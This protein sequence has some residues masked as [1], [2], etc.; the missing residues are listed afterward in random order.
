MN[1]RIMTSQ[2]RSLLVL[3]FLLTQVCS[4]ASLANAAGNPI[5]FSTLR[6]AQKHCPT[7]TVVWLNLPTGIYHYKGEKSYGS[8]KNGA[9]VCEKE[10][11][12]AGDRATQNGQ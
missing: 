5:L 9:F 7:D 4:G 3:A 6:Q 8:T 11:I 12:K 2:Y 10:A 1:R